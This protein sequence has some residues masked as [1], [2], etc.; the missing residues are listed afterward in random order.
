M[1]LINKPCKQ[2]YS[3]NSII[4]D[5]WKEIGLKIVDIILYT[6]CAGTMPSAFYSFQLDS[7]WC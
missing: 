6:F 1:N 7:P 2:V 3:Y 5:E 4:A